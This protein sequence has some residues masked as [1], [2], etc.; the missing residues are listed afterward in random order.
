[1]SRGRCA[2][3]GTH[4]ALP[5]KPQLFAELYMCDVLPWA[6]YATAQT[7]VFGVHVYS[8]A[9]DQEH[10]APASPTHKPEGRDP[11]LLLLAADTGKEKFEWMHIIEEA[12][13]AR[14]LARRAPRRRP[15]ADVRCSAA[16]GRLRVR[17]TRWGPSWPKRRWRPRS[18]AAGA[19][20]RCATT[21]TTTRPAR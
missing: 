5:T 11:D 7:N 17:A 18:L 9:A 20:P 16:G 6:D 13:R 14:R 8:G 12:R 3:T 15:P 21:L 1:M 19:S 4:D 10:A 2:R